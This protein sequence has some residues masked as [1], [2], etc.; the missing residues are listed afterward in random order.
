MTTKRVCL[1]IGAALLLLSTTLQAHAILLKSNPGANQ[2]VDGKSL[3]IDLAFNSRIDS[4]RSRLSLVQSSGQEVTLPIEQ[5]SPESMRAQ[6]TNLST[7]P[8]ILRWQVLAE[9]GHITRG[10]IPFQ[11]K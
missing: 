8:Y 3:A 7:G 9:D 1:A 4:K 5:P 10:D 6:V 2:I 11:V